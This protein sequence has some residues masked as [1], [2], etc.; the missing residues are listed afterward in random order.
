[1]AANSFLGVGKRID[2]SAQASQHRREDFA[3]VTSD[4]SSIS[5]RRLGGE[6]NWELSLL[7]LAKPTFRQR[8]G[9][10][11]RANKSLSDAPRKAAPQL[12]GG[13]PDQFFV[14]PT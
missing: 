13:E 4:L 1:M 10:N 12:S 5:Y 3:T 8:P 9:P 2:P 7:V 6:A 11:A 14:A